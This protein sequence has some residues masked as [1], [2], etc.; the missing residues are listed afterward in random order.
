[1][2]L[3]RQDP[4]RQNDRFAELRKASDLQARI[5]KVFGK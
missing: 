5:C 4:I 1:M 2:G 3:D